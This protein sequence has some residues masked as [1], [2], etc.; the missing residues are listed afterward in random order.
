MSK[1]VSQ[2]APL[3]EIVLEPDNYPSLEELPLMPLELEVL[4]YWERFQPTLCRQLKA[5]GPMALPTAIRKA[6]WKMEYATGLLMA[7]N[8]SLHREQAKELCR[9]EL[10]PPPEAGD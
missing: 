7:R 4:A 5:Q 1:D 8:P 3:N 6:W 9:A 10:W 2:G